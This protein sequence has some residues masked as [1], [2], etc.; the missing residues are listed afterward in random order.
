M[1]K[2]DNAYLSDVDNFPLHTNVVRNCLN[3]RIG[4]KGELAHIAN[5]RPNAK[6]KLQLNKLLEKKQVE[7]TCFKQELYKKNKLMTS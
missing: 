7:S 1:S 6:L 2:S 3:M 4:K 5:V